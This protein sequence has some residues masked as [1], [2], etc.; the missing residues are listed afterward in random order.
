MDLKTTED[1]TFFYA[2][3]ELKVS[4]DGWQHCIPIIV[5]D[6]T[7]LKSKYRGT[8][9]TAVTHDAQGKIL[10]LIFFFKKY[11]LRIFLAC[12]TTKF[13]ML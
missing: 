2:F 4:I 13:C 10:I 9:L 1:N 5:V 6:G 12:G 8:L 11:I 7:F 3:M